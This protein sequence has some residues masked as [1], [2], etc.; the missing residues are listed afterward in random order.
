MAC[1]HR[2][3]ILCML[4]VTHLHKG[5]SGTLSCPGGRALAPGSCPLLGSAGLSSF[6]LSAQLHGMSVLGLLSLLCLYR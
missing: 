4:V 6:D 1:M 2:S 5:L 3:S